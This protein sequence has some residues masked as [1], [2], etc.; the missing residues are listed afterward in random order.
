ML[1]TSVP[2]RFFSLFLL[3][4][5]P[6][7]LAQEPVKELGEEPEAASESAGL[8]VEVDTANPGQPD[9]D[10]ATRR[11]LI[12][13]DGRQMGQVI[14]LLES[15]I[16]KGL[17]EENREFAEQMLAASF[18]ER[19]TALSQMILDRP[20]PNP[21]QD[22]RWLQVRQLALVDLL[23][24]AKLDD[25]QLDAYL[26]IGRLQQLSLGDPE[27]AHRAFSTVIESDEAEPPLRAEAYA[28][29]AAGQKDEKQ[30]LSDLTKAIETDGDRIEY[31]LMRARHYFAGKQYETC[32]KDVDEVLTIKPDNFATHELRA[33]VLLALDRQEEALASF[34]RATELA[35]NAVTPYL[36][37]S[38]MYSKLGNFSQA[39]EQATKVIDLRPKNSLGYLMRADIY[40]RNEQAELGLKDA[41]QA[42]VL[43]PGLVQAFLLK[44]RAYELQGET[45]KA[46]AQLEELAEAMQPQVEIHLQ[47]ALYALQ[48][49]M[50]RRAIDALDRALKVEPENALLLRFRGD[51][52]LNLGQHREAIANYESALTHEPEDSG[53][54]NNLAWT[55]ATSPDNELR[56]GKRAVELATK[57]CVL[58]EHKKAHILSSLAAAYAE[59][60]DF[61]KAV[62]WSKKA[63]ELNDQEESA[64]QIGE[65]LA[66]YEAGKPWR[67]SQQLDAGERPETPET[68]DTPKETT[69]DKPVES[70]P[71]PGRTIDF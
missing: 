62:E 59:I 45:R 31:R 23:R 36:R 49:E 42:L 67:E 33:L 58:T 27:A 3:L 21:K 1:P 32:L 9:L 63:V 40:L 37:R 26:L 65:E 38:E 13:Q 50:P 24:V 64:V 15:S 28:R 5:A 25:S 48:L 46:L 39:I 29:R 10:E 6:F 11:K 19:G 43:R 68:T 70:T 8:Q 66:S 41:E 60:G 54:L 55:L 69:H 51:A 35:P 7:A 2:L 71:A 22:P 30:R 4:A 34:D 12:A 53:I 16:K 44:A 47:I 61:E 20:L 14:Q 52:N 17:D 57:A 18:L 56:E